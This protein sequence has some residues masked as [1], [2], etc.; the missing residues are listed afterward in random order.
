MCQPVK[1][2]L[3]TNPVAGRGIAAGENQ[4]M[5]VERKVV[6]SYSNWWKNPLPM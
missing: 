2:C 4:W 5:G 1:N 3:W 6:T